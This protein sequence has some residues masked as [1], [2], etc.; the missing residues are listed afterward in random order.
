MTMSDTLPP[1]RPKGVQE[2]PQMSAAQDADGVS[3]RLG[4]TVD[5]VI[6]GYLSVR[7]PAGEFVEISILTME[8]HHWLVLL[9]LLRGC[10]RIENERLLTGFSN[11]Y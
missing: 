9:W 10:A 7:M 1:G 5:E 6:V 2:A 3:F 4:H 8:P 11:G